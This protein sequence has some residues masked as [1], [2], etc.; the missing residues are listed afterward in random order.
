MLRKTVFGLMLTLLMIGIF[1]LADNIKPAKSEWTG[2]VYIRADGSIEPSDAPI[3][4]FDN[5][6]YILTGN[7]TGKKAIIVERDGITI[8]GAGYTISVSD[9]SLY[10]E[11]IGINLTQRRAITIKNI[12]IQVTGTGYGIYLKS[13]SLSRVLNSSVI[14]YAGSKLTPAIYLEDSSG[15][16]ISS[17]RIMG[18]SAAVGIHLYFSNN[19]TIRS[20]SIDCESEGIYIEEAC[21]N[22]I[23]D[24][25]VKNSHYG[26]YVCEYANDNI[27]LHNNVSYC[28]YGIYITDFSNNNTISYNIVSQCSKGIFLDTENCIISYNNITKNGFGIYT[29]LRSSRNRIY[30]NNFIDNAV[31]AYSYDSENWWDNGY[32]CGGNYWSDYRGAD[33]KSGPH[34]N[35]PGN[36]G[37]GDTPYNIYSEGTP[38]KDNYP[39]MFPVPEFPSAVSL[40][41]II[42]PITLIII[43]VK[44]YS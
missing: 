35:Q 6:T 24:N 20:N 22:V 10:G 42:I 39:L 28:D 36:D 25:I 11:A 12:N 21:C 15:N 19:N 27:I 38:A 31:Q 13:S 7:I 44:N 3:M 4:T 43:K 30:H 8:D 18:E 5:V 32:P 40:L 1:T 33:E 14:V 2:A 26:M 23:S 37:I 16:I 29:A 9:T 34:Q 17:N 41:L